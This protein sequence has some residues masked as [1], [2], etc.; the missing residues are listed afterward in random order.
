[1]TARP[2]ENDHVWL[3]SGQD[4][5]LV[6]AGFPTLRLERATLKS[7]PEAV[8]VNQLTGQLEGGGRVELS[9]SQELGGDRALDLTAALD[10]VPVERFLPPDW[11]ARLQGGATGQVHVTGSGGDRGSWRARGHVD[12]R[13]GHLEALPVLD[14]LAVFTTAASFRQAALQTG[15]ADFDWSPQ[16][17][18]V[19]KLILESAG[20]LRVEGG[21]TVRDGQI[22]GQFQIGVA[23]TALRWLATAGGVVFNEPEHDGYLWTSLHLTGPANNP[24]EDL[25]PRLAATIEKEAVDKAKQSTDAVI[26]TASSLLDL[27]RGH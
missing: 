10:R 17:L 12:L 27:L 18:T 7:T 26:D 20:L 3:V 9:G 19:S 8:F 11:R 4:G 13:D 23:R 5:R 16:R 25:T 22:D 21:F 2:G 1:M 14:Q 6:Q 24:H 15:G